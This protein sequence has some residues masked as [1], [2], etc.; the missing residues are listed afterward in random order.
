MK[1]LFSD[2]ATS[3][4]QDAADFLDLEFEGLGTAFE[5]DVLR[6]ATLISKYPE[7]GASERPGIRRVLLHKFPY[8]LIYAVKQSYILVLAVPHQHRDPN[9][10]IDRTR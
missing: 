2:F 1:V 7:A 3:E 4:V 5:E 9:Y 8:K 10:W 6:A